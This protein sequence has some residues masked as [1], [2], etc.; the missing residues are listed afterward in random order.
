[1]AG[2]DSIRCYLGRIE[3]ELSSMCSVALDVLERRIIP[4]DPSPESTAID[5]KMSGDL[6]RY[7]AELATGP[8]KKLVLAKAITVSFSIEFQML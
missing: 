3:R 5:C 6:H 2:A 1:M 4:T 7:T 8:Q